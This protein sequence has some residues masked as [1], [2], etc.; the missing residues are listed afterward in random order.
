MFISRFDISISN[1][2]LVLGSVYFWI[3]LQFSYLFEGSRIINE[4]IVDNGG[5]DAFY[6]VFD[7]VC[8]LPLDML[9]LILKH[10]GYTC[11]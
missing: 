10:E 5:C 1:S 4:E 9:E 3:F 8:A 7:F 11:S 2:I 6:L